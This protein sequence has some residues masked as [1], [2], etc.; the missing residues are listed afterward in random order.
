[1]PKQPW[2]DLADL[3]HLKPTDFQHSWFLDY[4]FDRKDKEEQWKDSLLGE[5]NDLK[6]LN[7]RELVDLLRRRHVPYSL[8]RRVFLTGSDKDKDEDGEKK[9]V[10]A[11]RGARGGRGGLIG[12]GGRG[13]AR[14]G[15]GAAPAVSADIV[16]AKQ[17]KKRNRKNKRA[18]KSVVAA[19]TP[20]L[21]AVEQSVNAE[22]VLE[23][24]PESGA[25]VVADKP[26][27]KKPSKPLPKRVKLSKRIRRAVLT[28]ETIDIVLWWYDELHI[29]DEG[30][31]I[32]AK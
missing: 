23:P 2:K 29:G 19:A 17:H 6:K 1:M 30:D 8:L 32:I 31:R 14:G 4:V 11:G 28:Y 10:R 24:V 20:A 15:R 18:K 9:P 16:K 26:K 27:K 3:V 25:V 7:T 13:G 12:R 5:C 22:P 21:V